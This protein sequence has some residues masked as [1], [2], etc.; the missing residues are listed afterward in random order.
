MPSRL[1]PLPDVRHRW[2]VVLAAVILAAGAL[3]GVGTA[4]AES[5]GGVRVMPLG[6][7]ITDGVTLP[8]AY[9]TGLWQRFT[10][11]G[12]RVDFVGS[13]SNGPA[14]LGDH[15]H[16]G[17]SGW[18]IDQIDAN[19]VNWLHAYS[20]HTVLLHIGTNDVLQNY[21]LS[22]APARLSALIDHITATVPTAEVF[23][24][25]IIPLANSGQEANARAYNS[26]IPGIVQ[27]KVNAGEHVHLVDMHAAL[28]TADL[29]SDGI[30]PNAT[31]FDKMAA[32]WFSALRSVPGSIGDTGGGTPT[33]T[34]T[35]TPPPGGRTC[36][37]AYTVTGQWSGGFQA[38]VTVTAGST[39][40]TGWTVTWRYANGQAVTQAW[41][42][43][44][45]SSGSAVTARNVGYNGALAA[46]AGAE[47]GF[48]GTSTGVNE[49]PTLTCTAN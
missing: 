13:L 3:I 7:S 33:P 34:P 14:S 48:L 37:A 26:A 30:H 36:T 31:G 44:V 25:T 35:P 17:H 39:A 40:I 2:A 28:T 1:S 16:E 22:G 41:N 29:L 4:R 8:G 24:A 6:D 23:V 27:S 9:R 32:A 42:A 46:G 49:V 10:G 19:I 5:N 21:N 18:R 15:D 11:G 38:S 47:F 45:T 20:P 43:T 12:Y